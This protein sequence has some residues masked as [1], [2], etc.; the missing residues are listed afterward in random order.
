VQPVEQRRHELLRV[1]LLVPVED[2]GEDADIGRY[3]VLSG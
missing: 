1:V 3:I 2:L